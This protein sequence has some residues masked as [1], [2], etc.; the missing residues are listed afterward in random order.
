M[1]IRRTAAHRVYFIIKLYKRTRA[2]AIRNIAAAHRNAHGTRI[3]YESKSEKAK[4]I[5][6]NAE[7]EAAHSLTQS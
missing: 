6:K 5:Y 7:H 3:S 4:T 2:R 1:G